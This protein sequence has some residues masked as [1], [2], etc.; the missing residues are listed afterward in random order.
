MGGMFEHCNAH[1][2]TVL[3]PAE[4]DEQQIMDLAGCLKVV[5]EEGDFPQAL[6][7]VEVAEVDA[8]KERAQKY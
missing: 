1:A 6:F 8:S 2:G 3:E 5:D 4:D 7:D